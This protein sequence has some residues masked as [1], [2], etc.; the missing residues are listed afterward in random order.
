MKI[1]TFKPKNKELQKYIESFY[2]LTHSKTEEKVSY[3]TFPSVFSVVAAVLNAENIITPK[4]ITTRSCISKPLETSL[5]CRF[6]KPICFQNLGD[7]KEICIYFKPLGLNAFLKN[8]LETYSQS[9]FDQ[10]VPFPDYELSM[11]S[12]IETL[13]KTLLAENLEK[14][15]LKKMIGFKH[16][17][18]YDAIQ[19]IEKSLNVT[20]F[21]LA[22][23]YGVSQK[24]LI[25]H[26]KMHLCKNQLAQYTLYSLLK[27]AN[28]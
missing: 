24:T 11:K 18:L 17:F 4:N 22:F 5:I 21:D 3:L 15:W 28:Y 13:D 12:I 14:Y 1:E 2:I 9:Y 27:S 20:T 26:F 8:P 25:K 23:E 10:F 7:I 6:N 16:P 19:K